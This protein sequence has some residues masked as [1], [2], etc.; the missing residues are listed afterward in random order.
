MKTT[1]EI[2]CAS[3]EDALL[4]EKGGADRIELNDALF[5]SGTTPS[6]GL[7]QKV[8]EQCTLPIIPMIRPRGAGFC[9]SEYEFETMIRD[10]EILAKENIKGAAFGFLK[11]NGKIDI[12]KTKTVVDILASKGKETVFHRAFDH[13]PD[14]FEAVETLIELGI[15]RILTSGQQEK[16]EGG[17][18]L[19]KELHDRYGDQIEIL[20]GS[21]VT[22]GNLQTIQNQTGLNQFHSSCKTWKPDPTTNA[23]VTFGYAPEPYQSSYD[24]VDLEKVVQLVKAAQQKRENY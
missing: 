21:G 9:Y 5:L 24:G 18:L 22:A 14:P 4:A 2:C 11:V 19:L 23:R 3:L 16:A 6:L 10:T 12:E 7:V 15:T 8:L 20:A 17:V 13:T 1:I